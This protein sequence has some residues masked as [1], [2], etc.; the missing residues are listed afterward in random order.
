MA[1]NR[2]TWLA[3]RP[4]ADRRVRLAS[5]DHG[6]Q[7]E[8]DLDRLER[9]SPSW[10]EYPKGVA[11][12]LREQGRIL[13][14][15]EGVCR[16]DVPMGAGLSS[17]ASFE[18]AVARAFAAVSG[19]AWNPA[20]MAATCQRAESQWVG[21][22]CGLMDQ[23]ASALGRENHALLIDCR[24]S[25][26]VPVPMP[27]AAAV[28]VLDTAT[29]RRL[30]DS[31][32]NDRRRQCEQAAG[33]LGVAVL[34]DVAGEQLNQAAGR[35]GPMLHARA[36]HVV[37]ENARTLRMAQALQAGD[38]ESAGRLMNESHESL[39]MDFEATNAAL[40]CMVNI[41]R[42]APGCFGARMTGA[43]FGGCAVAL[44]EAAQ[45][46]SF[47]AFVAQRYRGETRR[48]PQVYACQAAAGAG[49]VEFS[50]EAGGERA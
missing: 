44:V 40:D 35:L 43:G 32:Y 7:C 31:A 11:C 5:L 12:L 42:A 34:R 14:G 2:A 17:S 28:V 19:W 18:L 41:A 30:A 8:F 3:V 36:R 9:D 6:E 46:D 13:L 20:A 23:L 47:A 25:R 24:E 48:E 22:H 16:C 39:R 26:V 4:R 15:W 29:R 10:H 21:V 33:I 37:S 50:R 38:L 49:L 27:R 1:I 45:A